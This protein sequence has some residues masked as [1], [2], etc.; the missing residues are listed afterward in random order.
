MLYY[1][2]AKQHTPDYLEFLRRSS[3]CACCG[4]P[5]EQFDH[6]MTAPGI[7]YKHLGAES[8]LADLKRG[9]LQPICITCNNSKGDSSICRIHSKYLG[10]WN[11]LPSLGDIEQ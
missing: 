4:K 9:N 5:A 10:I 11:Y 8:V 2:W 3:K 6:I 1:T 7:S